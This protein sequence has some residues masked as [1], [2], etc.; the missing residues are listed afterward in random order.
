M[1]IVAQLNKISMYGD[2]AQQ[3]Q[4]TKQQDEEAVTPSGMP[5]AP[6]LA[7]VAEPRR[8]GTTQSESLVNQSL[9]VVAID[10]RNSFTW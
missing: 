8:I 5:G 3:V 9:K 7:F 6:R 10:Q 4:A 1:C 2:Y